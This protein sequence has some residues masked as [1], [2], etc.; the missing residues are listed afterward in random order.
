VGD[1]RSIGLAADERTLIGQLYPPLQ[2][3]AAVVAP[4]DVDPEDL[5]QEAFLRAIRKA[6]LSDL[7][8]PNAYLRKTICNL[9]S[10]SRRRFSRERRALAKLHNPGGAREGYPSDLDDLMT[11]RPVARAVLYLREIEGRSHAEIAAV[12]GRTEVGVRSIASPAKRQLRLDLSEEVS[13][14]TA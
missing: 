8:H 5:V 12:L 7:N 9:A 3:Y 11:L 14:A 2:R 10:N 1:V 6:P 4:V 13:S